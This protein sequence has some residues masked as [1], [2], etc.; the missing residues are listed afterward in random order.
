MNKTY[1][2][3]DSAGRSWQELQPIIL[4]RLQQLEGN[5]DVYWSGD[6]KPVWT[7]Y[8]AMKN[9]SAGMAVNFYCFDEQWATADWST[10]TERSVNE[11]LIERAKDIR[12][13]NNFV[14]VAYSGGADSH[15]VL[16]SFKMAGVAPDE[17]VFWTWGHKLKSFFNSNF[18]I[19]RAVIPYLPTIQQW[20]PKAKIIQ[21]DIDIEILQALRSLHP[22]H[23]VFELSAGF[24]SMCSAGAIGLF[25]QLALDSNIITVTGSD[26]P[27]L[28]YINGQWYAWITD[29]S[30]NHVWGKN[31]DGFFQSTDPT[32]FIRQCH[33][34]KNYLVKHLPVIN[35]NTV[36]VSQ[37]STQNQATR[38][39]INQVLGRHLPFND[40]VNSRKL[41]K[42]PAPGIGEEHSKAVLFYRTV[43]RTSNG[44][45]LL[46]EWEKCKQQFKTET[47]HCPTINIF[48]KF[49][50]LDTGEIRFVDELFPTGWNRND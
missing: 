44:N 29:I 32:I 38:R 37:A 25:D 31:I 1:E 10:P 7:K 13:N 36:L 34:L 45:Q 3:M 4:S 2:Y 15:T 18:E 47:G 5:P 43:K 20:F 16:T 9:V 8:Q 42:R 26:K 30:S 23:S 24:R 35:R 27:R 50:N 11:L 33:D 28:D 21:L 12:R 6:S 22:D 19:D 46:A 14:R 49:Y 40:S 41:S 39:V 17:I 48:G